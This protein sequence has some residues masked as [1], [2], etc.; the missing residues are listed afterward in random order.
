MSGADRHSQKTIS[1]RLPAELRARAERLAADTGTPL[2]RLLIEAI[3]RGLPGDT[4]S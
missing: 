4:P 2:R 1:I 3:E